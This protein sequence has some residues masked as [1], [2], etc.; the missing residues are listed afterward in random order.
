MIQAAD[1]GSEIILNGSHRS[2]L[3]SSSWQWLK[4]T[5]QKLDWLEISILHQMDQK[6]H[7]HAYQTFRFMESVL[8]PTLHQQEKHIWGHS[9]LQSS[10][11]ALLDEILFLLWNVKQTLTALSQKKMVLK[12][13]LSLTSVSTEMIPYTN[14]AIIKLNLTPNSNI[15]IT[16]LNKIKLC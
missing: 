8:T 5:L 9:W 16:I 3:S 2:H 1:R 12:L 4:Q 13:L 15:Y 6:S 10:M 7:S 14:K 11:E